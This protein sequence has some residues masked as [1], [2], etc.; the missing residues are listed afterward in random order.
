MSV[1]I[2]YNVLLSHRLLG[3]TAHEAGLEALQRVCVSGIRNIEIDIRV[4][5]D[6]KIIV[7]HDTHLETITDKRGLV[8]DY[9]IQRQGRPQYIGGGEFIPT[10]EEFLEVICSAP[11]AELMLHLDIKDPGCESEVVEMI[12][13]YGLR[14][15][16]MIVAWDPQILCEIHRLCPA[17]PLYFSYIPLSGWLAPARFFRPLAGY[18]GTSALLN[19]FYALV[20]PRSRFD[21]SRVVMLFNDENNFFPERYSA[22]CFLLHFIDILPRGELLAALVASKGGINIPRAALTGRIMV[23]AERS[24]LNVG[25]FATKS[26]RESQQV[27]SRYAPRLIYCNA[28]QEL[29]DRLG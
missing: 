10:L 15:R 21:L 23:A 14:E 11:R 5:R 24:Q 18:I 22:S 8:C 19:R 9:E 27:Y 29:L 26:F 4:T 7:Y 16:V 25:V 12:D 28:G 20:F 17:L 6:G 13:R 2:P 1:N 3:I